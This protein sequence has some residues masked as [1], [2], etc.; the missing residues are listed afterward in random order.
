MKVKMLWEQPQTEVVVAVIKS[1]PHAFTLR[2]ADLVT[3]RPHELLNGEAIECYI[4]AALNKFEKSGRLLQM[5]H[6]VTGVILEGTRQQMSRHQMKKVDFDCFDGAVSFVNINDSHWRFVYLHAPSAQVFVIDPASS[7]IDHDISNK[8]AMTYRLYFKMR[9]NIQ[10]RQHWS[11]IKWTAR[12]IKHN[13][14]KDS[15]SCGV[16][17]MQMARK[18]AE[19]FPQIPASM[20]INPTS[21]S[22]RK[23]RAE[24]AETMLSSSEPR[25]EYCSICGLKDVPK[26]ATTEAVVIDWTQCETCKRWFH[27]IC[28][29][30]NK[31][32]SPETDLPWHCL[33]C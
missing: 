22:I 26:T 2:H 21:S 32:N 3:L 13:E 10:G 11:S 28:I 27:D 12:T 25:D 30:L 20:T 1:P 33:L 24:M 29:T 6:Y 23:L 14:Q 9:Q 31:S 5:D 16:F 19:S 8:A 17:V 15:T 18:V 4:R 7:E